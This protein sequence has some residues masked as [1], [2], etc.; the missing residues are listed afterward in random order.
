MASNI[1]IRKNY[2]IKKTYV[3]R[4][5]TNSILNFNQKNEE[6]KEWNQTSRTD[7][8]KLSRSLLSYS[9]QIQMAMTKIGTSGISICYTPKEFGGCSGNISSIDKYVG[10][11]KKSLQ[12]NKEEK[13]KQTPFQ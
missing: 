6:E 13:L 10:R 9:Q 4:R 11:N 1:F 7:K 12:D 5:L 2:P 8:S 3:V